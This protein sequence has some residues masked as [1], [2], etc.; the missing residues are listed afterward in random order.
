MLDRTLRIKKAAT[1]G[2]AV[3]GDVDH[4]HDDWAAAAEEACQQAGRR[5]RVG[6]SG[7]A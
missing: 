6:A 1:I 5:S 3:R 2:E 4:T 7:I